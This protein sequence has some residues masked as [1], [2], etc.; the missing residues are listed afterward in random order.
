MQKIKKILNLIWNEFV[1]GGHLISFGAVS[2]VFTSAILLDI[3]ISWE[4]FIIVYLVSF[5]SLLYNRYKE[6]KTDFLTNIQRTKFLD[7]YFR[8]I[9]LIIFFSGITL[10][11]IFLYYK[12]ITAFLFVISLFIL[13][14]FYTKYLKRITSKI[15]VFK[16]ICFSVITSLLVILLSIYYS[17][18]LLFFSLFLILIFIFLRMFVNTVFLDI[19]DIESD[20]KEMLLTLPIVLGKEKTL[21]IL[22]IITILSIMPIIL[23]V[24]LGI[25]PVFS[26]MLGFVVLYTFYYFKK[27]TE[28]ENFHL[29]NY[30][31][32][33]F[34]FI[35]WS[36]LILLG[37]IFLTETI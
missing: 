13:S 2:I 3:D 12:K 10:I 14:F 24:Y 9:N 25:I 1:Y 27:S 35:L 36:V 26:L 11:L 37:K 21:K 18:S 29:V 22:E 6:N 30:I 19:K 4:F 34:E 17:H 7:K 28:K 31:L 5:S 23:G 16:N 15:I 32:A 8:H 20:K 33:D